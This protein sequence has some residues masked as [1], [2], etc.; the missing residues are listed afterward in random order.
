MII[1]INNVP[2]STVYQSYL[3]TV[4]QEIHEFHLINS[5]SDQDGF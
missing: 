4:I 2:V 1:I 5:Y 3:Q